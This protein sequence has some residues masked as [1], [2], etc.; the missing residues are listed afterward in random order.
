MM[1][2]TPIDRAKAA[3][4][5]QSATRRPCC[6]NCLHGQEASRTG[7]YNDSYPWRCHKGGFG[8]TA[9]AV[10]ERHEPKG[11]TGGAA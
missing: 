7:A 5:Y 10:C 11:Q 6:R 8:T 1:R 9:Q 4:G 3:M 2:T